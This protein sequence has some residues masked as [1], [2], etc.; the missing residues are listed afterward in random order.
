MAALVIKVISGLL[1]CPP[2]YNLNPEVCRYDLFIFGS[3]RN[4]IYS[5]LIGQFI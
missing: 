1:V 4:I 3:S 2:K 5:V